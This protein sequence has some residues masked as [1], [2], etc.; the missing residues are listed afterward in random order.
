[1]D[2]MKLER[3]ASYMLNRDVTQ[4]EAA[5]AAGY[6]SRATFGKH[7][8]EGTLPMEAIKTACE[9]WGLDTT[10]ALIRMGYLPEPA[11]WEVSGKVQTT[12]RKETKRKIRDGYRRPV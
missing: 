8:K 6:K 9:H 12:T 3:Y 7:S 2:K 11:D 4:Q 5:H 10:T 1:M